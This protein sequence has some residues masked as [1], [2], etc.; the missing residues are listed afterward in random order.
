MGVILVNVCLMFRDATIKK[1][2]V[3]VFLIWVILPN[4]APERV[5]P[6]AEQ[7][8]CADLLH[9]K[10][11]TTGKESKHGNNKNKT[12]KSKDSRNTRKRHGEGEQRETQTLQRRGG[13]VKVDKVK[14]VRVGQTIT[15]QG[16]EQR[17]GM[18]DKHS[19][20]QNKTTGNT[21]IQ[22]SDTE[23]PVYQCS[24]VSLPLSTDSSNSFLSLFRDGLRGRIRYG[25]WYHCVYYLL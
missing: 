15:A 18:N 12:Q 25:L 5:T 14:P 13:Q 7:P 8:L 2:P 1:G 22:Q 4:P 3:R 6:Q 21:V 23:P 11:T 17:Q 19:K 24:S 9:K 16:K 10:V 20:K